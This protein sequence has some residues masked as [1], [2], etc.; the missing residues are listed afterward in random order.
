MA[1][2]RMTVAEA[3]GVSEPY[4]DLEIDRG[5]EGDDETIRHYLDGLWIDEAI[6]DSDWDSEERA[7]K[8]V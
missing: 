2:I 3:I 1:V 5:G 8:D 4:V 6:A 7:K